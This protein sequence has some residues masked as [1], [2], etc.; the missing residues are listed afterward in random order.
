MIWPK[1]AISA[2]NSASSWQVLHHSAL[3]VEF[4]V[5][6][7]RNFLRKFSRVFFREFPQGQTCT[8]CTSNSAAYPRSRCD[9]PMAMQNNFDTDMRPTCELSN[10]R[11]FISKYGYFH[12]KTVVCRTI[13]SHGEEYRSAVMQIEAI[14]GIG[15]LVLSLLFEIV[16]ESGWRIHS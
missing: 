15:M 16:F 10:S 4:F 11:S 5:V 12:P 3:F 6:F 9:M 8:P 1:S 13:E 14:S 7:C 2:N